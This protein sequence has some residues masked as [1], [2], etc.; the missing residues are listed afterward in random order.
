MNSYVYNSDGA[1]Y[2]D[3]VNEIHKKYSGDLERLE[4]AEKSMNAQQ[5]HHYLIQTLQEK[6]LASSYKNGKESTITFKVTDVDDFLRA[7]LWLSNHIE[8]KVDFNYVKE[9]RKFFI[10]SLIENLY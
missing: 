1:N 5:Y 4:A 2:I 8:G 3:L 9:K 7:V 6:S 10:K